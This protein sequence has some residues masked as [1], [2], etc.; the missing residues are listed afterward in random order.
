MVGSNM[1][2]VNG[3]DT[4]EEHFHLMNHRS[5]LEGMDTVKEHFNPMNH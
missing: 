3:M 2:K 5:E 1:V 4:V